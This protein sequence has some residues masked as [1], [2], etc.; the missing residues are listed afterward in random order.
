MPLQDAVEKAINI[1]S[2][3][4]PTPVAAAPT[5]N[6]DDDKNNGSDLREEVNESP[7]GWNFLSTVPESKY[8]SPVEIPAENPG[9]G[10]NRLVYFVCTDLTADE[11]IELPPVTPH[12]INV[13][14][15]ITRYLTG[16]L[17]HV[18]ASYP[19]TERVYLRA[20]IAR[21]SAGTSISPRNFYQIGSESDDDESDDDDDDASLSEFIHFYWN[22]RRAHIAMFVGG[23]CDFLDVDKS[24]PYI[25][26]PFS[27]TIDNDKPIVVNAA[28]SAWPTSK[29]LQL[30]YW[31]HHKPEILKQGRV[32][33]FDG[34]VLNKSDEDDESDASSDLEQE[35]GDG[36]EA[37]NNKTKP[38]IPIPLFACLSGDRLTND[39]MSISP[40]TIRLSDVVETL[41]S[42]QSHVWPGAFAFVK[43]R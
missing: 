33:Y 8:R 6:D 23:N 38:E 26:F 40:W 24:F 31:E 16:D 30:D 19:G 17:D 14:R 4:F 43:D 20:L 12:Q 3:E 41:V 11:W 15:R 36:T 22:V 9:H 5:N 18:I 37:P 21:I 2:L 32:G 13:S 42:A 27:S 28:Y 1:T 35:D 39:A 25:N 34:S 10:V 29:L 7:A